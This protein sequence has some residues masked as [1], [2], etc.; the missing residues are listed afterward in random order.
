ML[1]YLQ[2]TGC[3]DKSIYSTTSSHL[4][5]LSSFS[6]ALPP[7]LLSAPPPPP[8]PPISPSPPLHA[9]GEC[10]RADAH[11]GHQFPLPG[12]GGT[13]IDTD[14]I[15]FSCFRIPTLLAGQTPGVIHAFAEGRRG[16]LSSPGACPD[17]PDTRLVYKRSADHGAT[18]STL[19][20]FLQNPSVRQENGL[21]QSQA[22]PVFDPVTKTLIVGYTASDSYPTPFP[23]SDLFLFWFVFILM[24]FLIFIFLFFLPSPHGFICSRLPSSAGQQVS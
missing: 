18:W 19:S 11:S 16:E 7:C 24:L 5:A 1:T 4:P 21:C 8:P 6:L 10:N 2:K 9:S 20:I 17:G 13:D 22:A 12:G 3:A 15:C 14:K 23:Y